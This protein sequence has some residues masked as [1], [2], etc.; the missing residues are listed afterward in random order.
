MMTAGMEI[1][2]EEPAGEKQSYARFEKKMDARGKS[3]VISRNSSLL[4]SLGVGRHLPCTDPL[5][6]R[7]CAPEKAQALLQTH[8]Q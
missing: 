2:K 7:R 4:A 6:T 5:Y 3:E 8:P 1:I